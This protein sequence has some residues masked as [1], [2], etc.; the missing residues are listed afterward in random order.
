MLMK[1]LKI[2]GITLAGLIGT[3]ILSIQFMN[4]HPEPLEEMEVHCSA[5]APELQP[6]EQ[7]K[8]L[9]WNIQYLAGKSYVF[10]YDVSDGS[11]KDI[12][13]HPKS[14]RRSENLYE[15]SKKR[16]RTFCFSRK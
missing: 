13:P 2:T 11:G 14:K 3:L 10:W 7:L 9:N 1:A 4:Y 12:P 16:I 15:S 5:D 8:V 6:G